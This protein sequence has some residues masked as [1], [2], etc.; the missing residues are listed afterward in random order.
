MSLKKTIFVAKSMVAGFLTFHVYHKLED[1]Y[2]RPKSYDFSNSE[3]KTVI[4]VGTGLAGVN[5]AYQIAS[6]HPETKV[7]MLE[8]SSKPYLGTSNHNGN[9]LTR[10]YSRSWLN[11]PLYPKMYRGLF[12]NKEF[13]TKIYPM[14]AF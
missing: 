9:W 7:I 12:D 11:F 1:T 5:S 4:I 3:G 8:R 2:Y 6:N 10:D 13:V 14:S